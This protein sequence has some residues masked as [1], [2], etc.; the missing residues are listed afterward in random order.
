[1]TL[2][3][4]A[5]IL[6]LEIRGDASLSIEGIAGLVEAGPGQLTFLFSSAYKKYL[7]DTRAAAVVI[8]QSDAGDVS[9][10]CIFSENPRLDWARV[11]GIFDRLPGPDGQIHPRAE[12]SNKAS[13]G[14]KVSISA[15]AVIEEGA[16]I[17]EGC[18]IGPG[19]FLGRNVSLGENSRLH[20]NVSIYHES[21]IGRNAIIHSGTVIGSDGFGFEFD[22]NAG[23][24]VKIPQIYNVVIGDDVELGAQV[25]I[26][27]GA[28]KDTI[29][30][31]GIKLDNQVHVG[32]GV[33]IGDHT[34]IC[35][36]SAIGGST[37]IGRYCL[38]GGGVGIIDN[39]E[40]V[41]RVE[42]TPMTFVTKPLNEPGRYTSGTG[43]MKNRDWKRNVVGFARLEELL[44]RVRRLESDKGS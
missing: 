30:G 1:M 19:C 13:I 36:N 38:I 33:R 25:T 8:R 4:I 21:R 9:I 39:I 16:R 15:N 37:R 34:L 40:I 6:G 14:E 27:R 3:E 41:D 32:H 10:P 29:L 44:K 24:W 43:L 28:L 26:D 31:N 20:A 35:A 7:N 5:A 12:I 23:K 18:C 22:Q 17:G 42:V 2:A 11:A